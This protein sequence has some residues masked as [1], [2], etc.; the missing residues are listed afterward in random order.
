V[1][2]TTLRHLLSEHSFFA[3]LPGSDLDLIA[4]CGK[5]VHFAADET[6]FDAGAHADT[7][8]VIRRGKVS[9]E[10]HAPQ[11]SAL[12]IASLSDGDVVGWSWLFPPYRWVFDA[13]AMTETS[14]IALDGACLR[15]KCDDDA[16]LGYRLMKQFAR[17]A[18]DRL[19]AARVQLLDLYSPPGANRGRER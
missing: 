7:F 4:G 2:P 18:T 10:T 3:G 11:R 5:N 15:G 17:I 12:V 14:A 13:R 1:A 8:Y 6:L 19:Q 9:I 16:E